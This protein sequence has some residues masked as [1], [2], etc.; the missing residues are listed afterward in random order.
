M[1]ELIGEKIRSYRKKIGLT[2]EEVAEHLHI[3]QPT[4]A[5]IEKGQSS[6]WPCYLT[7]LCHLFEINLDFFFE[8]QEVE[9]RNNN[10][11]ESVLSNKLIEQFE[12]RIKEKETI[13]NILQEQLGKKL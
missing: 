7:S 9:K 3:S 1:N 2:Q 4:Y 10:T 13:I 5:R 8:S 6:S 12:A 11:N